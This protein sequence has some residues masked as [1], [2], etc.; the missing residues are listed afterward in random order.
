M[1]LPSHHGKETQ[2][3]PAQ[4]KER[5]PEGS[6][7]SLVSFH[8]LPTRAP[9]QPGKWVRPLTCDFLLT[10][11]GKGALAPCTRPCP[12]PPMPS[13]LVGES[14][15]EQ[16]AVGGDPCLLIQEEDMGQSPSQ[17]V[18]KGGACG[19]QGAWKDPDLPMMMAKLA[20]SH[21]YPPDL[22][23]G[24]LFSLPPTFWGLQEEGPIGPSLSTERCAQLT[25]SRPCRLPN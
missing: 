25:P 14:F 2:C 21:L 9:G 10:T 12:P 6:D 3:E 11:T 18:R 15:N 20:G 19:Y 4:G 23:E 22:G 17:A 5:H 7:P 1:A 24:G 16:C 13:A 8:L